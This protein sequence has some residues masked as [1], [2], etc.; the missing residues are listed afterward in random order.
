MITTEEEKEEIEDLTPD[1]ILVDRFMNQCLDEPMED[2]DSLV[3]MGK[4]TRTVYVSHSKHTLNKCLNSLSIPSHQYLSV[5]D[6]GADT[7][8]IGKGWKVISEDQSRRANVFGFDKKD[9]AK[10]GLS[11]FFLL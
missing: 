6:D 1:D 5:L 4:T 8:V 3:M 10:Y 2:L 7:C 9:A 11:I